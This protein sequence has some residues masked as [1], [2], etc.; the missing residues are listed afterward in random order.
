MALAVLSA[1]AGIVIIAAAAVYAIQTSGG[2][3]DGSVSAV[4]STPTSRAT[5]SP[6]KGVTPTSVPPTAVPPTSA[7]T[8]TP[9]PTPAPTSS[10]TPAPGTPRPSTEFFLWNSKSGEWQANGLTKET[11]AYSEGD[12]VPFLL[13]VS[14]V[15]AGQT[16]DVTLDAFDCGLSPGRSFDYLTS[17]AAGGDA[18]LL[19]APA[20]GRARPDAQAPVPDDPAVAKD[21]G[22]LAYLALWG[23]TFQTAPSWEQTPGSCAGDQKLTVR[24]RAQAGTLY[25]AWGGHLA[26]Q[27]D[28]PGGGAS[29]AKTSF[30]LSVS[31]DGLGDMRLEVP[32]SAV[33]H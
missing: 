31:V 17:A 27:A 15:K 23:G 19:A 7:P 1:V 33:S 3:G 9:K 28:W 22:P 5:P 12:V 4:T 25:L 26:S 32:A 21:G 24:V 11:S 2:D 29:S 14:G 6:T 30:G 20:P 16:Y 18:P 8:A 10:P 13:K